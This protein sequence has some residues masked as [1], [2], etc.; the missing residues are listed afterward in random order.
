ME[1]IMHLINYAGS[2]GSE[3]YVKVLGGDFLIYN[4]EGP[5]IKNFKSH[6]IKMRNPLDFKAAKQIARFCKKNNIGIVH[7]HFARENYIAI[8]SK[9]FGS[10]AKVIY[11]SH[12]NLENNLIWKIANK[13]F[14][15]HNHAI[16]A[17]CNS[18]RG[19]LMENGYNKRKIKIIYNGATIAE[20]VS[21]EEKENSQAFGALAQDSN[22]CIVTLS[23]LSEE[24]G[25]FF[26]CDIAKEMPKQK[27][28]IA[29]DGPL[30]D[31]LKK[32]APSNVNFP[33]HINANQILEKAAIYINTS[34]SEA[35]SFGILE[36]LGYGIP[37]IAT[38]VGGNV[39]IIRESAAGKLIKYG[40]IKDATEKIKHVLENRDAYS[41][42]AL[43]AIETT[44]SEDEMKRKTYEAYL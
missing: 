23:R 39:D 16:I 32:Y 28:I 26:L 11:T 43:K 3:K 14:T 41:K 38:S 22:P 7:T 2:G 42:S 17:V 20:K 35:L 4:I 1:K 19:L 18:V 36:A 12:I 13:I 15:R 24:K 10:K 9:L 6:Q 37:I 8:L 34:T 25:L 31:K 30:A 33:G 27:F 5:L 44:F 29:G 40:D 21:E